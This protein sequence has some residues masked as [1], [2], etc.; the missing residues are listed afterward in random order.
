M[1][2]GREGVY[3]EAQVANMR[4]DGGGGTTTVVVTLD[5]AVVARNQVK[6]LSHLFRQRGLVGAV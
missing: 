3:T 1:L 5:G 4:G 6:H 2:H